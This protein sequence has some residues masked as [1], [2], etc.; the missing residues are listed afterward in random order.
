MINHKGHPIEDEALFKQALLYEK[1]GK[2]TEAIQNFE[3]ILQL[4]QDDI[5]IDD[6]LYELAVIYDE[7]LL[8]YEKAKIYYEKI[9]LEQPSSIYLVP[10]RK[11]FR[12]LRG[13]ELIP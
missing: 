2:Y 5:L 12:E 3:L 6:T 4:N 11:R 9:V 10:A 13:D 7:K 1:L 8:D